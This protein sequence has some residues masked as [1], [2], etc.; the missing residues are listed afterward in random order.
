MGYNAKAAKENSLT[1]HR[2]RSACV[3]MKS[4]QREVFPEE[5]LSQNVE[6]STLCAFYGGLLTERQRAALQLHYDEDLSLQ[7]VA[8]QLGVSRQN[9]HDLITRSA[10]KLRRY[11]EAVGGVAQA[12]SIRER[13][14]KAVAELDSLQR[15]TRGG[16]DGP[17]SQALYQ[18][19]SILNDMDGEE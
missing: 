4:A 14:E 18:I 5:R 12:L 10:Q 6:I 8:E 17:V 13:L 11:E 3:P 19:Q 1:D 15:A 7:E 2:Q 9:V 16:T